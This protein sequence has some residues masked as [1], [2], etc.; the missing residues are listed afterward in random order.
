MIFIVVGLVPSVQAQ[1]TL[2]SRNLSV[3]STGEDVQRLQQF[4]NTHNFPVAS[5]GAGSLGH[6]TLFFGSRTNAA[7]RLFQ[8][9]FAKDILLP[10]GLHY[11]TGNFFN[12]TRNFVNKLLLSALQMQAPSSQ[13]PNPT[14]IPN[15]SARPVSPPQKTSQ[16][17]SQ[18]SST[19]IGGYAIGGTI[20]GLKGSVI[21]G[22]MAETL[23]VQA[24]ETTFRFP[25][26]IAKG[27][28]YSLRIVQNPNNQNCYVGPES[29]GTVGDK[30]IL[31]LQVACSST[32]FYP[33]AAGGGSGDSSPAPTPAPTPLPPP[34]PPTTYTIGGILSG[35]SGSVVLQNNGAD[36]LVLNADGPFTF[37][38]SLLPGVSYNVT[39]LT[40][41]AG[42]TC[43]VTNGAGIMGGTDVTNVDVSCA[44]NTTTLAVSVPDLAL[45][46]NDTALNAALTG[47]PRVFTITNVGADPAI[48][49]TYSPSPALPTGTT[50]AP[51]SCGTIVPAASCALTITPGSTPSAAAGDTNPTPITL[52]ISGTNTNTL[53]PTVNVLTYSSVYQ[54]GY[55]YSVDDTTLNTTSIGG[56]VVTLTDQAQPYISTGPQATSIIWSSNGAGFSPLDTSND[57]IPFIDDGSTPTYATAQSSFNSTYINSGTFPFPP[58]SSFS[59]CNG[60]VDGACN[61]ANVITLYNTYVTNYGTTFTLAPGPTPLSNYAAGL[62]T[63]TIN[64]HSDWY[65]PAVCEMDAVSGSLTC[66]L[67]TQSMAG[68][69]P[70][71]IGYPGAATPSTSCSPGAGSDCLAGFYWSSTEYSGL[72]Q[73][74]SWSEGFTST[75][76]SALILPKNFSFGVRCSRALSP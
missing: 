62:C 34:P 27:K 13:V 69:L 38:G 73:N 10:I 16:L 35:L 63:A 49:V 24:G 59:A 58:P 50:I 68:N 76:S 1:G 31:N 51:A 2:F 37:N 65:L 44:A 23:T 20:K 61:S 52:S 4:L 12:S 15:P 46:V 14:S 8:Q 40:Q 48:N 70:A 39:V 66:P 43:T 75:G 26:K 47:T 67:G 25:T 19:Q 60:T 64:G 11:A 28:N 54:G 36:N 41:P 18:N 53:T 17:P 33:F 3:G 30:D 22:N 5:S 71:L 29:S 57:I 7:L 56:K 74:D 32:A 42:Q 45:S 55:L 21:L 6:E 9:H 72:P